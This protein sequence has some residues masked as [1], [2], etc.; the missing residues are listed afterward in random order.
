MCVTSACRV[1]DHVVSDRLVVERKGPADLAASIKDRRLFEQ[2]A[3]LA[4]AYPSV[5]GRAA[6]STSRRRARTLGWMRPR[7]V[8]TVRASRSTSA[9]MASTGWSGA[10]TRRAPRRGRRRSRDAAAA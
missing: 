4:D 3:R 9:P 2:L 6:V 1:G 5:D 7:S 10:V 8:G